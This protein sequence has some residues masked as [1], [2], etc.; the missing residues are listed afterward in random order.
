MTRRPRASIGHAS[1]AWSSAHPRPDCGSDRSGHRCRRKSSPPPRTTRARPGPAAARKVL[2][3]K[4][5][6]A[7]NSGRD[8]SNPIGRGRGLQPPVNVTARRPGRLR[9][10]NSRRPVIGIAYG[11]EL[12]GAEASSVPFPVEILTFSRRAD[13]SPNRSFRASN[14]DFRAV[15]GLCQSASLRAM[16]TSGARCRQPTTITDTGRVARGRTKRAH[17]RAAR[18]EVDFCDLTNTRQFRPMG[19]FTA[20]S[21]RSTTFRAIRSSISDVAGRGSQR[22]GR[23]RAR[24]RTTRNRHAAALADAKPSLA[25]GRSDQRRRQGRAPRAW[26]RA[27]RTRPADLA[28]ARSARVIK[29]A[30]RDARTDRGSAELV[31]NGGRGTEAR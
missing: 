14:R 29:H 21:R 10:A 3:S 9:L 4:R 12:R 13:P 16:G 30:R 22:G 31:W 8:A 1:A 20:R 5:L 23:L 28:H 17:D 7:A 6:P 18:R 27:V 11:I 2:I 24:E 25:R 15:S 26:G 19:S